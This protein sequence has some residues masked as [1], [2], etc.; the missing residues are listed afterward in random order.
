[1]I[2]IYAAFQNWNFKYSW[3]ENH[4]GLTCGRSALEFQAS[5][6]K[7]SALKCMKCTSEIIGENTVTMG[8]FLSYGS[9]KTIKPEL[10][11]FCFFFQAPGFSM[12]S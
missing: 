4:S 11:P 9:V 2:N 7:S 6:S 12:H 3:T 1:M 5:N 10:V 8:L